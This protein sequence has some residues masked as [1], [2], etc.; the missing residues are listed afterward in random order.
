MLPRR[1]GTKFELLIINPK[2]H[3]VQTNSC[4]KLAPETIRYEIAVAELKTDYGKT[5]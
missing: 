4:G 3:K 2:R 1:N 5:I